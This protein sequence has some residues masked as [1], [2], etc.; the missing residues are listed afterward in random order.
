MVS[1]K[2]NLNY[3]YLNQKSFL[4]PEKI[5]TN[6]YFSVFILTKLDMHWENSLNLFNCL[7]PPPTT[8]PTL[9]TSYA[10]VTPGPN[11]EKFVSKLHCSPPGNLIC[12]HL[13][14]WMVVVVEGDNIGC[15]CVMY[16]Q[17]LNA[18]DLLQSSTISV[19]LSE[20]K[21]CVMKPLVLCS[22]LDIF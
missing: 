5:L 11:I 20:G 21:T 4:Q 19:S 7:P 18:L 16:S 6:N 8:A 10:L 14:W 1:S 22:L 9:D 15:W 2:P 13:N 17:C 3:I 12:Q